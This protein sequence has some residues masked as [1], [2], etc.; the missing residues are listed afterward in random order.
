MN[1]PRCG[2]SVSSATIACPHCHLD[3]VVFR[4]IGEIRTALHLAC[5]HLD[6]V[7][8]QLQQLESNLA[9]AKSRIDGDLFEVQ[10]PSVDVAMPTPGADRGVEEPAPGVEPPMAFPA[11]ARA[12]PPPFRP[13]EIGPHRAAEY[14]PHR[15]TFADSREAEVRL[16]Q[17]WLLIVGIVITVLAVGY[18]LK[19]SFDRNWVGPAGRVALAYLAGVLMLGVG[20][21]LRRRSFDTFGLY[22]IGGGIAVLYFASYA[23][24]QIYQLIQQPVAFAL[25]AMVTAFAGLLSLVYDV[26]WLAVLGIIGGFVTPVVLS[27]GV[28]NQIALM[29]YMAILNAGILAIAGFKQ[30]HLLNYLGLTF[31]WLL[32]SAWF[33]RHYAES[34]FWTTTVYLNLFF[35]IYA[36]VPF[37]YY[38]VRIRAER[39]AGFAITLPNSFIA[40]GY[41]Y[42]TIYRHFRLEYVGVA[43]VAYAALFFAMASYLHR[44]N[45]E[46]VDAFILLIAKGLLFLV[47]TVPILFSEHW[48]TVFWAA[49]GVVL[50]WAALR[51]T[52]ARLRG[53]AVVLLLIAVGK[54]LLY[55]YAFVFRL[56]FPDLYILDGFRNMVVERWA[57]GA[58]CAGVLYRAGRM[59]TAAGL[60][61]RD[62]R[63]NLPG[64]FFA[65]FGVLLFVLL[66]LET[67]AFFHEF[68]PGARFAS[69]SVLWALFAAAMMA[70][71][72]ARNLVVL[73]GCA[74]GLFAAVVFK[75]FARDMANVETPYR[76]L[77]FLI[78]GLM[79]VV[80]SYWYHRFAA[81]ILADP[82]KERG[83]A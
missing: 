43:T 56:Q 35:L 82:G 26:K 71:G 1:C 40:F 83:P 78:V 49:L 36:L 70:L 5:E 7:A 21:G 22:L 55:D 8:I 57:T 18:F 34:K 20:E 67:A 51:L 27:T 42:T 59:L 4:S 41:S 47:I 75:V 25:M 39:V 68:V 63:E 48:I 74:I 11:G 3:L 28:D 81:R 30:W 46:N 37:V 62:W 44:K 61:H 14:A 64:F 16:G 10:P 29:T 66:N 19:Y 38:F 12:E 6:R 65:L 77:S 52:D 45:R 50:L 31:T 2:A 33:V 73:R 32:F 17:K 15:P 53:G 24:F 58:L 60:A 79:L 23:A 80:A 54:L 69:I 13:P 9:P 72:F 76:I